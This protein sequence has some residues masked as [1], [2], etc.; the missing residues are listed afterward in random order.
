MWRSI[1]PRRWQVVSADQ[2]TCFRLYDRIALWAIPPTR[3]SGPNPRR[4][5][6]LRI[7]GGVAE[8]GDGLAQRRLDRPRR[9]AEFALGFVDRK[10][11]RAPRDPHA[12]RRSGGGGSRHMIGDEFH[13]GGGGFRDPG[14][15]RNEE[16]TAAAVFCHDAKYLLQRDAFAAENVAMP[17]LPTL[18]GQ[19]QAGC[20]VAHVDKVHDEIEIQVKTPVE[21]MLEHRDGRSEVMIVK[22]D[23]HGRRADDDRKAGCRGS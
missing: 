22:P 18:H 17:N 8:I 11:R 12:F 16:I 15:D 6:S 2:M 5:G 23:G 21:K 20:D 9:V 4:T 10:G 7:A 13:H 1:H 3:M 19:Y 14:G